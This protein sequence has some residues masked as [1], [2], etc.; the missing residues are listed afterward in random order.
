MKPAY[1]V[2]TI[3]DKPY[4]NIRETCNATGLS[5]RFLREGC[6]NGT[7][8]H[9]MSGN[10]YMIN[11]PLMLRIL[12]EQSARCGRPPETTP[13]SPSDDQTAAP[14]EDPDPM[15]KPARD[16]GTIGTGKGSSSGSRH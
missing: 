11:I 8:P 12:D 2:A 1:R 3:K 4:L 16:A 9:I 15:K 14:V 7:I 5:Q 6:K 13:F 10:T